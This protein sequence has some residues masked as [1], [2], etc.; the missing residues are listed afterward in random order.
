ML[1]RIST[2]KNKN[3]DIRDVIKYNI[4]NVGPYLP[5]RSDFDFCVDFFINLPPNSPKA[6]G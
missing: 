2:H 4:V 5:N 1:T 3:L 6:V